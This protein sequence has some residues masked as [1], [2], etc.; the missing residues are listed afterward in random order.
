MHVIHRDFGCACEECNIKF[1]CF[2]LY[3]LSIQNVHQY[4]FDHVSFGIIWF[5][6]FNL[7]RIS[8]LVLYNDKCMLK[9]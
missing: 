5:E 8:N 3:F 9:F 4:L 1:M 6:T 2:Y 7:T